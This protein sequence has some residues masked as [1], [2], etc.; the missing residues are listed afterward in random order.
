M[1]LGELL[2]EQGL[3]T[4]EDI[5]AALQRQEQY[6][7]RIGENLVALGTISKDALDG[8]LRRQYEMATAILTAEDLLARA[9]RNN[10]G[11]HPL[12][13]RHRARLARALNAAGRPLDALKLAM[14]AR[15]A[16]EASLGRGHRW[17]A[18]ATLVVAD[19]RKALERTRS[20]TALI[21][22]VTDSEDAD[23][24]LPGERPTVAPRVG[25]REQHAVDVTADDFDAAG[26][27]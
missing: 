3:V 14:P 24:A 12:T 23:R 9:E 13:H 7:G 6:G 26:A 11:D 25:A 8:A 19:A 4:H 27:V 1:L 15:A 18:D 21:A 22:L 5:Q 2:V 17:T 10:G 16:L 20:G